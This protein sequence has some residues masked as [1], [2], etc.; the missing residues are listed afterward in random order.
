MPVAAFTFP[1]PGHTLVDHTLTID[2]PTAFFTRLRRGKAF[3]QAGD[4]A[5]KEAFEN[6]HGVPSLIFQAQTRDD[7]GFPGVRIVARID[8]NGTVIDLILPGS[9]NDR[10]E[11]GTRRRTGSTPPP[12]GVAKASGG[13][14]RGERK[15]ALAA[16]T[17]C[18]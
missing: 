16:C 7:L 17:A 11:L 15:S 18:S 13:P 12:A 8:L 14:P 3:R 5:G 4:D 10:G 6:S 2:A 1:L 9:S